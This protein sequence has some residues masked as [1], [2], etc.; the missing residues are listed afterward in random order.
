[1]FSATII[2]RRPPCLISS[3]S[4][5]YDLRQIVQI[6][7][8]KIQIDGTISFS[9]SLIHA[10]IEIHNYFHL[11]IDPIILSLKKIPKNITAQK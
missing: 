1:M 11:P 10:T 6:A 8:L 4:T 7:S 3:S 5:Q 9:S 2:S